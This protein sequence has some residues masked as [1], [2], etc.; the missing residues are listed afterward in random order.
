M[1]IRLLG[2]QIYKLYTS[3]IIKSPY[4]ALDPALSK[5]P[6]EYHDLAKVFSKAEAR[7]LPE[8]RPYDLRIPLQED[9]TP[10][11]G[12]VYNLSPLLAHQFSLLKKRIAAYGSVSTTEASIRSL[13]RIATPCYWF[14]NSL[15]KSERLSALPV[16]IY[17]MGTTYS[18]WQRA[19]SGRPLSAQ[20]MAYSNA[21]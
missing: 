15:I 13:S 9:T 4:P 8:H 1:C 20:G 6:T 5:I 11:F 18:E 2:S 7:K 21:T 3:E 14:P 19:R 12:P 17:A 10:L 16:S